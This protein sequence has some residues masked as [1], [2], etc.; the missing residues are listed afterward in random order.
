MDR[1][2]PV[3]CGTIRGERTATEK[4][5]LPLS[6]VSEGERCPLHRWGLFRKASLS[7]HTRSANVLQIL[8]CCR[9]GIL[10]KLRLPAP[11]PTDWFE[12]HRRQC[13]Q[14]RSS[15]RHA[16]NLSHGRG[17]LYFLASPR[18]RT[19]SQAHERPRFSECPC[20]GA[21][22]DEIDSQVRNWRDRNP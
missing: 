8:E 5:L 14:S 3:S 18:R 9:A 20:R 2:L 22:A 1:R 13:R 10:P 16:A 17:R 15:R 4:W 11:V 7:D 21:E 6:N 12:V 19:S